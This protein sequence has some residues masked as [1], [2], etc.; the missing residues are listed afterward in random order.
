[1]SG[2][3]DNVARFEVDGQ[4]GYGMFEILV[5]GPHERYGFKTWEDVA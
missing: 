1:M 4:V 3:V 2:L 5:A